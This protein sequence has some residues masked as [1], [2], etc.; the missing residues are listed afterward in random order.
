MSKDGLNLTDKEIAAA[1]S[2]PRWAERFPPVLTVN[3]AADLV[4]VPRQT[5]Y[6]WSSDGKLRG[7][8]R[9]AGK[10]LR[11]FRDRFVKRVF[12]QGINDDK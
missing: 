8:A 2:E 10:H 7:C 3:Q 12:N 5:I 11:I 4:S 9:K 6:S 1:F